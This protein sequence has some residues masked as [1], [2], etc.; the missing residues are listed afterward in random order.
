MNIFKEIRDGINEMDTIQEQLTTR[1]KAIA[2]AATIFVLGYVLLSFTQSFVWATVFYIML[3]VMLVVA[4]LSFVVA[5]ETY[6]IIR[7]IMLNMEGMW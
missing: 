1:E 4:V 2:V 5:K 3:A 7:R 6:Y